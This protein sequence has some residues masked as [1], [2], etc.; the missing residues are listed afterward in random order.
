MGCKTADPAATETR[1]RTLRE[2]LHQRGISTVNK[3]DQ[4][5][6]W[7]GTLTDVA[8]ACALG[9]ESESRIRFRPFVHDEKLGTPDI[10][11]C[12][13]VDPAV[14]PYLL[15]EDYYGRR[16]GAVWVTQDVSYGLFYTEPVSVGAFAAHGVDLPWLAAQWARFRADLQAD[17]SLRHALGRL[18]LPLAIEDVS[19]ATGL[20]PVPEP[21]VLQNFFARD[22]VGELY[23]LLTRSCGLYGIVP[24]VDREESI[25]AV[26]ASDP[27]L[28]RLATRLLVDFAVMGALRATPDPQERRAIIRRARTLVAAI[29]PAQERATLS[30]ADAQLLLGSFMATRCAG[31]DGTPPYRLTKTSELMTLPPELIEQL[32]EPASAPLVL[33]DLALRY[34]AQ[35]TWAYNEALRRARLGLQRADYD[36]TRGVFAP[37][38]YVERW[39]VDA[40][41]QPVLPRYQIELLDHGR[42]VRLFRT[43]APALEYVSAEPI[44]SAAAFLR[45]LVRQP[46]F[47]R[48]VAII[49]KAGPFATEASLPPAALALPR[50]GSRYSPFVGHFIRALREQ[51]IAI[52]NC[53]IVRVGV[54]ALDNLALLGDRQLRLPPHLAAFFCPDRPDRC[55]TCGEFAAQWRR[56]VAR[57]QHILGGMAVL[58]RGEFVHLMKLVALPAVEP[59]NDPKLR[60]FL[61]R[62]ETRLPGAVRRFEQLAECFPADVRRYVASL[63]AEREQVLAQRRSA[64]VIRELHETRERRRI[65]ELLLMRRNA[66]AALEERQDALELRLQLVLAAQVRRLLQ[67]AESLPYL[68]DR[69]YTLALYLMFGEELLHMLVQRAEFDLEP[70]GAP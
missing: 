34:P 32:G 58:E 44:R 16:S 68:N 48:G 27:Q 14:R 42:R 17:H 18:G 64:P 36:A 4:N 63:V 30:V 15:T 28:R 12:C 61:E 56:V 8:I 49:G 29:A 26:R 19:R 23:Y 35:F 1:V 45:L 43:G 5:Q 57:C 7:D 11:L 51:G 37:P 50:Q 2:A 22:P 38:F 69:P 9:P 25:S 10:R 53:L 65:K 40:T 6:L 54:N 13:L 21:E 52:D 66:L 70:A 3:G 47:E 41:G 62:V 46:G 60:R 33:F 67:V 31:T 20:G 59:Q 39:E 24:T 55:T